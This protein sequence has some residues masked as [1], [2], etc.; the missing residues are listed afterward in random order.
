MSLK[1]VAVK[2]RDFARLVARDTYCLHCGEDEAV[3]PNHRI[4]RGMGGKHAKAEQPAKYVLRCSWLNERIEGSGFFRD[5]AIDN[6][7]KLESWQDP[8][9]EPVFDAC[10]GDWFVLDNE[11]GRTLVQ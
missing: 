8:T 1:T 9:Q 5:L 4:N 2:P 3:S 6:G 11:Y 10:S 7:W